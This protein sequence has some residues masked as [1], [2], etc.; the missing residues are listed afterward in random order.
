MYVGNAQS[1]I[2][3]VYNHRR[4]ERGCAA[5]RAA[6]APLGGRAGRQGAAS[7]S[8]LLAHDLAR[9][10]AVEVLDVH[11]RGRRRPRTHRPHK[12]PLLHQLRPR[13]PSAPEIAPTCRARLLWSC[14]CLE[15]ASPQDRM[16][17]ACSARLRRR[18]TS[19]V[20]GAAATQCNQRTRTV[21]AS[22]TS[23]APP[24]QSP[25]ASRAKPR[26]LLRA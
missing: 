12:C 23:V 1:S 21:S 26:V 13:G 24:P 25:P 18:T 16:A 20:S 9:H 3:G 7:H 2:T 5:L 14:F 22:R 19:T 6:A 4:A 8:L 11:P 17:P 15:S 10:G